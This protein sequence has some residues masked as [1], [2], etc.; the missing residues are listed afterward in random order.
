MIGH[1]KPLYLLCIN[2]L[3]SRVVFLAKELQK[4][5]CTKVTDTASN[6]MYLGHCYVF[7]TFIFNQPLSP[8]TQNSTA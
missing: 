5:A 7:Y 2:L 3:L 6:A 8:N 4:Q 1:V